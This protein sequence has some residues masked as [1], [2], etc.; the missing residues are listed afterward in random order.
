MGGPA[1]AVM[2]QRGRPPA[3][4]NIDGWLTVAAAAEALGVSPRTV[5]R[6]I[7]ANKIE[8]RKVDYIRRVPAVAV[9][10]MFLAKTPR[11]VAR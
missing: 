5:F 3:R 7:L 8:S 11:V 2:G 9:R 10:A 1:S 4:E 6:L